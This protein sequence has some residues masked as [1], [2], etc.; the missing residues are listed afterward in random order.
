MKKKLI[1]L[2]LILIFIIDL[3]LVLTENTAFIDS[4]IHDLVYHD[5]II[6][7]MKYITFLGSAIAI[8]IVTGISTI[9][10]YLKKQKKEA[11]SIII[12]VILNAVLNLVL[13]A[14]ISRERPEYILVDEDFYSFPS[15]HAMGITSLYGYLIYII[16]NSKLMKKNKIILITLFSLV[17]ISVCISRIILG[18]HYFSDIIAGI[19]ISIFLIIIYNFVLK[20]VLK[21]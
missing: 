19:L 13:K 9:I 17:I 12:I 3:I 4:K 5:D 20:K 6:E 8:P 11:I 1:L 10:L 14:I 7:I 18:A 15:G 2:F 21:N 16:Y